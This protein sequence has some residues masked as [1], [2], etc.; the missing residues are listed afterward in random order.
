MS[1]RSDIIQLDLPKHCTTKRLQPNIFES[2]ANCIKSSK[3]DFK[4]NSTYEKDFFIFATDI[5]VNFWVIGK[6]ET[7]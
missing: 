7:T 2:L 6:D 3:N 5:N 1:E 4:R